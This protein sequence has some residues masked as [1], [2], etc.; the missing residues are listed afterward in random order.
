MTLGDV[1]LTRSSSHI[2]DGCTRHHF[3]ADTLDGNNRVCS[4]VTQKHWRGLHFS[5]FLAGLD[6]YGSPSE[7]TELN[8]FLGGGGGGVFW[9]VLPLRAERQALSYTGLHTHKVK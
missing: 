3:K 5:F 8:N 2:D 4:E 1:P 6:F 7:H 9:S